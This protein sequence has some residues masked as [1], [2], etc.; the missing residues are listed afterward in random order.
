MRMISC[1]VLAAV[2]WAIPAQAQQV[3]TSGSVTGGVGD[4][5]RPDGVLQYRQVARPFP[6]P[7]PRIG[8]PPISCTFPSPEAMNEWKAA[9]DA[10]KD[11]P[12]EVSFH[13]RPHADSQRLCLSGAA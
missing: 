10:G 6:S 8:N 11:V 2:L 9:K 5:F 3:V 1:I 12:P 7:M 4:P 13:A